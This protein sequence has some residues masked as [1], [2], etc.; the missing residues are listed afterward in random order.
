[1]HTDNNL[2]FIRAKIIQ[3]RSAIMYNGSQDIIRI[4][5][6]I[7]KA[8]EVDEEGQL[9][10]AAKKPVAC[11]LH[12]FESSFPARLHFYRKG[13]LFCVEASGKATIMDSAYKDED[14]NDLLLKMNLQAVEYRE[15]TI[16][17]EKSL[18]E[19][20]VLQAYNWLSRKFAFPHEPHSVFPKVQR[21]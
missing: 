5:N 13:V 4:P 7:V 20:L 8:I 3:L 2:T 12:E 16:R 11:D 6:N 10:L 9:W 1:M 21:Y 14:G 17:G 18:F 15:P 19:K